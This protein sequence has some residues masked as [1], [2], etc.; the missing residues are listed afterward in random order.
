MLCRASF[1]FPV[2]G[3]PF[4]K[5][6]VEPV[7]RFLLLVGFPAVEVV[8]EPPVGV[9]LLLASEVVVVVAVVVLPTHLPERGEDPLKPWLDSI[10]INV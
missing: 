7:N 1:G 9:A 5:I 3:F 10:H 8:L 2:S 4:V 6:V